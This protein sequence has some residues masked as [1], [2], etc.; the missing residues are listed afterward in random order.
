VAAKAGRGALAALLL[1]SCW[2]GGSGRVTSFDPAT[3][4]GDL[5]DGDFHRLCAQIDGW[6]ERQFSSPEFKRQQCEIDAALEIRV[7]RE[8]LAQDFAT[9]CRQTA[10][11]CAAA[12]RD[13]SNLTP[14]CERGPARCPKTIEDLERCL[15]DRGYNLYGV[16]LSAPMCDDICRS[17]DPTTL[18]ATSCAELTAACPGYAFTS[19]PAFPR[20]EEG[21]PENCTAPP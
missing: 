9:E 15:T 5:S 11:A 20:L 14:R 2:G 21:V 10:Q 6:S 8:G 17:F 3:V 13:S 12:T 7:T 4:V 18:D 19:R 16:F 1:A